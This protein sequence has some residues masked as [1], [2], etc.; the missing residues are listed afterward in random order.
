MDKSE[1]PQRRDIHFAFSI[2]SSEFPD[3]KMFIAFDGAFPN[4]KPTYFAEGLFIPH[5]E[6]DGYI[7]YSDVNSMVN[8][9]LP[10]E[11]VEETF[12]KAIKTLRDGI[13]GTNKSEFNDEFAEYW[14]RNKHLD[15][16]LFIQ[17]C[18]D[19]PE[20]V[21]ELR[22]ARFN[23]RRPKPDNL[24]VTRTDE[25]LKK[26][27]H[28]LFNRQAPDKSKSLLAVTIKDQC[29]VTPPK[30]SDFWSI[31]DLRTFL[32]TNMNEDSINQLH[33]KLR[34]IKR[35]NSKE[36]FIL[37][38]PSKNGKVLVALEFLGLKSNIHPLLPDGENCRI[39]PIRIV[40]SDKKLISKRGG[41]EEDLDTKK[42]L[43]VGAGSVGS[44][45]AYEIVKLGIGELTIIDDDDLEESNLY[46]H[47]LGASSLH[48]N[49]AKAIA[50]LLNREFPYTTVKYH[51]LK[52]EQCINKAKIDLCSYDL[53]VSATGDANVGL[54]L[55]RYLKDIVLSVPTIYCWNEAL[56]IGGH[57]CLISET[58]SSCLQCLYIEE[59]AFQS[60]VS[61][62]KP[63][64]NFNKKLAGCST[65]FVPFSSLDSM[66]TAVLTIGL[67]KDFLSGIEVDNQIISWKGSNRYFVEN[68]FE[69]SY[70]YELSEQTLLEKRFNV[71]NLNED[72]KCKVCG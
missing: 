71:K 22:Y 14:H 5:V 63:G 65:S 31:Q 46:R 66:R 72:E 67:V 42:I 21:I 55:N 34:L 3:T 48:L 53:I 61:F 4:S 47:E 51:C 20:E 70:R 2:T 41:A 56:G 38:I 8:P 27:A 17:F 13:S 15:K 33:E 68:G 19:L 30:Y 43:L 52:L 6:P 57:A 37:G 59:P 7:C 39:K 36:Y 10:K 24:V 18:A 12:A 35:C 54:F 32:N 23:N 16:E 29:Y 11:I 25:E 1:Y 64:Q 50:T 44:K 69:T 40:R 60:R 26:Y 28:R 9:E 45:L 58:K 49:K 62:S